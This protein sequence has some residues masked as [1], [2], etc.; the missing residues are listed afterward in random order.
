MRENIFYNRLVRENYLSVSK[1][2]VMQRFGEGVIYQWNQQVQG[3]GEDKSVVHLEEAEGTVGSLKEAHWG[4][5]EVCLIS[6]F[7]FFIEQK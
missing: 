6:L 3:P 2:K 5:R 7:V 1:K 4:E